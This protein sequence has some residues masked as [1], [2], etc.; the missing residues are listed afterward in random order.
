LASKQVELKE[1]EVGDD[2]G[3]EDECSA[4]EDEGALKGDE[5]P[6]AVEEDCSSDSG[7]FS[8]ELGN[9]LPKGGEDFPSN[10]KGTEGVKGLRPCPGSD[11]P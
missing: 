2:K 1:S 4:D 7:D 10:E 5:L 8:G 9:E 3:R 6:T 11:S